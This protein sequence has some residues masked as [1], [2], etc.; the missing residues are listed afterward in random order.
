MLDGRARSRRAQDLVQLR[1][2]HGRRGDP[3]NHDQRPLFFWQAAEEEAED[4]PERPGAQPRA[5]AGGGRV[6]PH[7]ID[8]YVGMGI[9]NAVALFIMITLAATLNASG[10]TDIQTFSQYRLLSSNAAASGI[11]GEWEFADPRHNPDPRIETH[12]GKRCQEPM[13]VAGGN[14]VR[15]KLVVASIAHQG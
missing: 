1:L 14:A 7:P 10:V 9:S 11:T 2:P 13:R 4:E 5:R 3:G 6:Y 12:Q 15:F 8:T